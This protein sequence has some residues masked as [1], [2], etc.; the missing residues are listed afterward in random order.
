MAQR[1]DI[2][3]DDRGLRACM[4]GANVAPEW[5]EALMRAHSIATLDDFVYLVTATEWEASIRDLVQGA[6][7]PVKDNRIA[8]ARFKSAW[9]AGAAALKQAM[10]AA[11]SAQDPDALLPETTLQTLQRDFDKRYNYRVE[12]FLDPNDALRSRVYREF[13]KKSM[14][15]IDIKK[16]KSVLAQAVPKSHEAVALAGGLKLEFDTEASASVK[17]VVEYF[18]QLKILAMAW[19]WSGNFITKSKDN[20]D[21]LMIDLT[22]AMAY[23]D[24]ALH[25]AMMYGK[26]SVLWISRNDTATRGRMA[27]LIRQGWAA[28]EALNEALRL[29]HL[30]WRS[31]ALHG[32]VEEP[33]PQAK[34]RAALPHEELEVVPKRQRQLKSD[35]FT[36]VSMAKGGRKICKAWNDGRGCAAGHKCENLHCCDV[37]TP[38]GKACLSTKHSRL[39]H[40]DAKE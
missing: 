7:S 13:K 22:T 20:R 25:D 23:P 31:P 18:F 39:Q 2:L 11:P 24:V 16:I 36:T 38:S 4:D 21:V 6:G 10:N 33:E 8:L 34:K 28:G 37:K 1:I 29:T 19:A 5:R 9:E 27:T 35:T 40:N 32:V 30:E 26:G 15:I 17:S 3:S 14:S 12:P